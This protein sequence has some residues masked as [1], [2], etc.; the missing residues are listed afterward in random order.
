MLHGAI[1]LER[2]LHLSCL[3]PA[4][5]FKSLGC[6]IQCGR[7]VRVENTFKLQ[8]LTPPV[9]YNYNGNAVFCHFIRANMSQ[10]AILCVKIFWQSDF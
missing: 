9:S 6:I 10:E 3:M 8:N 5:L 2:Q 1:I 7:A 4:E